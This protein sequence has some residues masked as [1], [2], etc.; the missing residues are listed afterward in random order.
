VAQGRATGG[1]VSQTYR[2][3]GVYKLI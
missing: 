1:R 3:N 2:R